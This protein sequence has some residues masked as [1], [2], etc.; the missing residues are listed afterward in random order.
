MYQLSNGELS[1]E[2]KY[3]YGGDGRV[4]KREFYEE[5]LM[6]YNL[7]EYPSDNVMNVKIFNLEDDGTFSETEVVHT[8]DDNPTPFPREYN[9]GWESL[10]GITTSGNITSYQVFKDG[11]LVPSQS[12]TAAYEYNE[13]GYPV[14][15]SG[16]PPMYTYSCE[17]VKEP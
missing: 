16:V 11:A 10:G 15:I 12:Y 3:F 14:G 8:M 13:G 4:S 6:Y 1:R 7:Y 9:M 17:P 5:E 2:I